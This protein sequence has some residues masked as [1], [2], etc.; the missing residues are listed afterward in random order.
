MNNWKPIFI[1]NI[2]LII[3]IVIG[4]FYATFLFFKRDNQFSFPLPASLVSPGENNEE[5]Q[6]FVEKI[7]GSRFHGPDATWWGYNQSKIV[8]FNDTV[9]M[10]VLDNKDN[11][12]KTLSELVVYK[13]EGNNSWQEGARFLTGTPGNLLIDS[14]G[15][16][17]L[18]VIEPK[19]IQVSDNVGALIHYSFPQAKNGDI[20]TFTREVV[21]ENTDNPQTF[22][23]RIG[24]AIG[25]DDTLAI[26][27]GITKFNPLYKNQSEHIYYKNKNDIKWI[28]LYTDNLLHD[29]YYPFLLVSGDTFHLLTVQ[30][31]FTGV[32]N[33]NIYQQ[34]L[35]LQFANNTWSQ[36]LMADYTTH[37]LASSRPRIV[38]QDDLFEDSNGTIHAI[39][40][41]N[42]HPDNRFLTD[43]I[44]WWK[45]KGATEW[46][47]EKLTLPNSINWVRLFEVNNQVY[48]LANSWDTVYIGRLDS[49][50]KLIKIPIT[51]AIGMYPYVAT[52]RGAADSNSPYI[53]ILL[54]AADSETFTK[55]VQKNYYLR[56]S[57][58]NLAKV[59]K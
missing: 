42:T 14:Q 4:I 13:K 8:R 16:L 10:Y 18:F 23:G 36:K 6:V 53:D 1:S 56:L 26:A 2:L 54:L 17:H 47:Q 11:D 37:P 30:D 57:K 7:P 21:V 41:E 25:S 34:I 3:V 35:Y 44:H 24:T 48:F 29:Y 46:K 38:E 59:F 58:E 43:H 12:N 33:P 32:G 49:P 51:D 39:Y 52:A 50:E 15:I 27:V 31:D 28:H 45:E 40:K 5:L 19:N 20:A 22:N 9:F 55:G